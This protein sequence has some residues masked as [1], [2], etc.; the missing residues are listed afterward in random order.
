MA[1]RG[2]R[3]TLLFKNLCAAGGGVALFFLA[4]EGITRLLSP[5]IWLPGEDDPGWAVHC[6]S[7]D[8]IL[9]YELRPGAVTTLPRRGGPGMVTYAIDALGLR[10]AP[11]LRAAKPPATFRLLVL[12]DSATFGIGVDLEETVVKRLETSWRALRPGARVECLNLGVSGYDAFQEVVFLRRNG[13]GLRPDAVVVDYNLNDAM[14]FSGELGSVFRIEARGDPP[15]FD[16]LRRAFLPQ[17]QFLRWMSYR[18]FASRPLDR[19]RVVRMDA[20]IRRTREV[21]IEE[22]LRRH[23]EAA[24]EPASMPNGEA[25]PP[26]GGEMGKLLRSAYASAG[27]WKR[28]RAAFLD[29]ADL[30]REGRFPVVVAILPLFVDDRPYPF[31][32]IHRFVADE[33]HRRGFDV[34]DL[35]EAADSQPLSSISFDGLHPNAAGHALFGRRLAERL[36]PLTP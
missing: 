35:A 10:D 17:S 30:A 1:G 4:A 27:S 5:R 24:A 14:D 12:G 31:A 36:V 28:V 33:A 9:V 8:P 22:I 16:A 6:R 29:L 19:E 26:A 20:A 32:A 21:R 7:A 15:A 23:P 2:S 18:I 25:A 3:L 11:D 34:V 13:L